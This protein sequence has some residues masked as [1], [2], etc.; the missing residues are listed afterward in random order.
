[1]LHIGYPEKDWY[2]NIHK[3]IFIAEVKM[4]KEYFLIQLDTETGQVVQGTFYNK[5]LIDNI[6]DNQEKIPILFI[7]KGFL[8]PSLFPK[9]EYIIKNKHGEL[10]KQ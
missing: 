3:T 9:K 6:P 10:F 8:L 5:D 4:D 1:M 7:E 2:N